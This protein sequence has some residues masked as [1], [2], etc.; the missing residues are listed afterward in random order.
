MKIVDMGAEHWPR[1][2]QIYEDGIATGNATFD[3]SPPEWEEWNATHL[4]D[5]RF[6]ALDDDGVV[7]GWVAVSPVSDRCAYAGVGENSIYVAPEAI[8]NGLGFA[9]LQA[10]IDSTEAAGIWTIQCGIFPENIA[11]LRLHEKAGFRQVGIRQRIGELDGVWRDVVL[12]ERRSQV[13]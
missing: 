8:G 11:S 13:V 10:L 6:V 2:K 9:L 12:L 1:V 5:H 3:K 7:Q 4:P